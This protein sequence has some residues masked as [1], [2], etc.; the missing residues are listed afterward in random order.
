MSSNVLAFDPNRARRPRPSRKAD[1]RPH[2]IGTPLTSLVASWMIALDEAEKSPHTKRNYGD[3][4]RAFINWLERE[5]NPTDSEGVTAEH[6]RLFLIHEKN[7]TSPASAMTRYRYLRVFW[8]WVIREKERTTESPMT[9]VD[10]IKVDEKAKTY[11]D[12]DQLKALLAACSGGPVF[13]DRRDVAIL[14][15]FMDVGTRVSGMAN[16]RYHPT[17]EDLTDVFLTKKRLRIRLKGGRELWVPLGKKAALALDRYLRVRVKHDEADS[18]WLWLGQRGP[19]RAHMTDSGIRQM[20]T[21]R[22][23]QAGVQGAHPHRFR[24]TFADDYLEG[25]GTVDGL[26]AIAGWSSYD[27]PKLYAGER[28]AERARQM[29]DRLSPGDRI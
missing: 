19:G 26:M 11:F 20:V 18:P 5:G 16:L 14:R 8:N 27:M 12:D 2:L 24:R 3:T 29:H 17:D 1:T 7:R 22:G 4:M 15:I 13:V 10:P 9:N 25:G 6:C 28:A 21:R 23:E